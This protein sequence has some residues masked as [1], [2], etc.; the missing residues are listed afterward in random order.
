M[1]IFTTITLSMNIQ[2][3]LGDLSGRTFE[4]SWC[5]I[6]GYVSLVHLCTM[7]LAF[8]FYRLIRILYPQNRYFRSFKFYILI[9]IVEYLWSICILSVLETWNGVIYLIND[10]FCYVSFSNIRAVMWAA[11]FVYLL[12]SLGTFVIY[13]RLTFFLRHQRNNLTLKIKRRQDR[14][15]LIVK[16][17]STIVTLLFIL[18]IPSMIFIIRFTIT[19]NYHPLTLRISCLP[20]VISTS[21]LSIVLVFSIPQLK[22]LVRKSFQ[23][24]QVT[25]TTHATSRKSIQIKTVH[26]TE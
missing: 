5:I 6:S 17:I 3:I 19:N 14:D 18:G 22:S 20:I 2:T 11:A 13:T 23:S 7:Y 26:Y 24:Q 8:A 9:V 12:P 4:S 25:T 1:F 15:F 16:R 10:S 21:S